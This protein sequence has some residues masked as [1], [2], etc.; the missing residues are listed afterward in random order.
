MGVTDNYKEKA[1]H[2]FQAVT[3]AV[4]HDPPRLGIR[5]SFVSIRHR[6]GREPLHAV[7]SRRVEPEFDASSPP[8]AGAVLRLRRYRPPDSR[9]TLRALR[10]HATPRTPSL[11]RM[12]HCE[13]HGYDS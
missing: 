7:S 13:V 6:I 1:D 5:P 12:S 9:M 2:E 11:C 10:S 8:P 3:C 4:C